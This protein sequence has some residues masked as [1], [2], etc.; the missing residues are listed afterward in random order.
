VASVRVK[1]TANGALVRLVGPRIGA[2]RTLDDDAVE[3]DASLSTTPSVL[4]DGVVIPGGD[5]PAATLLADPR[6]VEF[7]KDQY[8]H[9]KTLLV[10]EGGEELLAEAGVDE[11]D[12][13]GDADPGVVVA[14]DGEVDEA[15]TRFIA[16]LAMHRH[17]A[18]E[19]QS[20][21]I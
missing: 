13:D 17:W 8:E 12:E 3:A 20:S 5:D 4:Y 11:P 16:A 7:V 21:V 2:I 1:L 14:G 18:R 10:F 19:R 15:C 6:A 9:C